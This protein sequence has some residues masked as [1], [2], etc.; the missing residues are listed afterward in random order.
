MTSKNDEKRYRTFGRYLKEKYNCSVRK[1]AIHGNFS[2]PN[3]DGTLGFHGCIYC[4][5]QAFHP[6]DLAIISIQDQI[7]TQMEWYLKKGKPQ[8]FIA[9]FQ[10]FTNTYGDINKLKE[11]YDHIKGFQDI[12]ALSI[13]TRPDCVTPE[14]LDLIENYSD[15][16]DVWIE[17]G[18]QSANDETL[19]L[20]HRGHSFNQFLNAIQLTQSRSIQICVHVILGLPGETHEDVMFTARELARLPIH[21]IKFHPMQVIRGS[22]LEL[23]YKNNQIKLLDIETY[24]RWIIDFIEIIPENI[25]IQRVTGDAHGDWLIA[26]DWCRDKTH[27]IRELDQTLELRDT[28]QG[29]KYEP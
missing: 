17:Y 6:Q 24:I 4:N 14:I 9:Y 19:E 25:I 3:R 5:N 16:Y 10:T 18:L 29:K 2:C 23:V 26:P 1:L 15:D 20:I 22:E 8:K 28:C 27:L 12:V 13:G 21:A 11:A 7:A